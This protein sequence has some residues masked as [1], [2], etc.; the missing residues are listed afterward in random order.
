MQ[1]KH[2]HITDNKPLRISLPMRCFRE[3]R[4]R[5]EGRWRSIICRGFNFAEQEE[6]W[7]REKEQQNVDKPAKTVYRYHRKR[8]RT[9][10]GGRSPHEGDPSN[11]AE[12]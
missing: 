4:R 6:L 12:R 3:I 7:T 9:W 2:S 11:D 1:T 8:R 10:K 5:H